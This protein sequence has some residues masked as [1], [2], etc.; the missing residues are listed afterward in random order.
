VT[1]YEPAREFIAE[2]IHDVDGDGR[3]DIITHEPYAD[4]TT[5]KCG[6]EDVYP[7][8]GPILLAHSLADGAFSR[9]DPTA[10][11]FAKRECANLP[12]PAI[13]DER[14]RPEIVDFV[15]SARNIACAR[16]WGAD[17]GTL[18][19]QISTRCHAI[20]NCSTCDDKEML[21]RWASIDPPVRI[22]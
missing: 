19:S 21:E 15:R 7:V 17:R 5:I 22:R 9:T 8:H 2:E 14:D 4:A 10:I 6:S 1:L 3:P 16:L 11:S 12:R 13:V 18:L 20:N